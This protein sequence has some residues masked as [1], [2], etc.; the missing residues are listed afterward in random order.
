MQDYVEELIEFLSTKVDT[1]YSSNPYICEIFTYFS[2]D[3][4]RTGAKGK[5]PGGISTQ[6]YE[7]ILNSYPRWKE[8]SS[9]VINQVYRKGTVKTEV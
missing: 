7:E 5:I 8:I 1:D 9:K 4:Q 2:F 3:S 6:S